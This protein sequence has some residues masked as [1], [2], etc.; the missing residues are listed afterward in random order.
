MCVLQRAPYARFLV[1]G[2]HDQFTKLMVEFDL[3]PVLLRAAD[4]V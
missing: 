3:L 2:F 1:A 4:R